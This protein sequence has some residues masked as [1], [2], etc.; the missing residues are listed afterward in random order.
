MKILGFKV[1]HLVKDLRRRQSGCEEI[2]HVAHANAH[3]ADAGSAAALLGMDGDSIGNLIHARSITGWSPANGRRN[4]GTPS[5]CEPRHRPV[6]GFLLAPNRRSV[7][8]ITLLAAV[9]IL[10]VAACTQKSETTT[11]ADAT[12][13]TSTSTTTVS[14]T[15][16][17]VDTA[18]TAEVKR[19]VKDASKDAAAAARDAAHATG[20]AMETAGKEIQKRSKPD[21]H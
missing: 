12:A 9:L 18:A 2:E 5:I 4:E 13:T 14:A 1:G 20:T 6:A 11:S 10:G 8:K 15:V 7:M 19:D 17:A 3:P 16:P 21:R